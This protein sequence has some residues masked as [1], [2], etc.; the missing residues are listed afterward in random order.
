MKINIFSR[1]LHQSQMLIANF[2]YHKK[3]TCLAKKDE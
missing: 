2:K 3:I 1:L